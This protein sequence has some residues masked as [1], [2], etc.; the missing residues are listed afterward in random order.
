MVEKI[1]GS[2]PSPESAEV[3]KK[4]IDDAIELAVEHG[5]HDGADH[6]A[7]AIDKMVRILAGDKYNDVV[8]EAKAGEDGPDTYDWDEGIAP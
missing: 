5:G 3:L 4:R 2:E 7:W 1:E 6:K 8:K